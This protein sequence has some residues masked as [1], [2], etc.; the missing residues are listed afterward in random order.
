MNDL[1][2]EVK[3]TLAML[4]AKA[5]GKSVEVRIPGYAAIQ[6]IP[7]VAHRRGK[8]TAVVETDAQTWLLLAQGSL[9]WEEA[10]RSGRVHAVGE[11]SNLSVW[12][13]LEH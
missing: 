2:A 1:K 13:P 9:A 4:A 3:R 10:V 11:R 6:C 7:G 12:L 8:P 5:P